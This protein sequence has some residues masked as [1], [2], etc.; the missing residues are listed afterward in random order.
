MQH[1]MKMTGFAA[2]LLGCFA[3]L[4]VGC[5]SYRGSS[6]GR[7]GVT[8]TTEAEWDSAKVL[9]VSLVEFS[10][11]AARAIVQDLVQLPQIRDDAGRVTVILGDINNKTGIVSST[12]F[13]VVTAR[14]RNNL[15]NSDL[16]RPTLRFVERRARMQNLAARE[17]VASDKVLADPPDYDPQTTYALNGDFYRI[18]RGETN[19]YYMEVQLVHF[20]SNEIVFSDRYDA[21]HSTKD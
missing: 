10:D 12:E 5:K 7:I 4:T 3:M 21:K 11:Q 6:G 18:G 2:C 19:Q 9:P 8:E 20:G 17:G 15:I 1:T 13:E 14:L 16:A